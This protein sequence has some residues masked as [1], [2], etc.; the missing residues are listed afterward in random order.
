[1]VRGRLMDSSEKSIQSPPFFPLMLSDSLLFLS[2]PCPNDSFILGFLS[3]PRLYFFHNFTSSTMRFF[4]FF[5]ERG[6]SYRKPRLD[7]VFRL[8]ALHNGFFY[9]IAWHVSL[10][11][12]SF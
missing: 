3:C 7:R 12:I 11:L 10:S 2:I 1:M 9:R 6:L 4:F 8:C 5:Y